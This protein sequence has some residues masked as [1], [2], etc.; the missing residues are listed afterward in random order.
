MKDYSIKTARLGLRNWTDSDIDPATR[1]NADPKVRE[2]FPNTLTKEETI[3]F[4]KRMQNHFEIHGFCFFAVDKL[5]TNEFIGFIGLNMQTFKSDFT[6]S[7][8]IGWRLLKEYWGYGFATEGAKAC[9]DFAFS[10]LKLPVVYAVAPLLNKKS[11]S[12]MQKLG[13]IFYKEFNHPKLD[14]HS[15]LRKCVVFKTKD[16][17][18]QNFS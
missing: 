10:K 17:I 7:V 13:M 15:P 11:Q 2:F 8:E 14:K 1:M 3:D 4:I 16:G 6:P 5:D 12:V 18:L 9:L